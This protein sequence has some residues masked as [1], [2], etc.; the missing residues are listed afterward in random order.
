MRQKLWKLSECPIG[1]FQFKDTLCV[2]NEYGEYF[3]VW[4]GE[5]FWGGAKTKQER[6]NLLVL[7]LSRKLCETLEDHYALLYKA[8]EKDGVKDK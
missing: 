5:V 6:D 7:P 4:S 2:K 3:I 8:L 1:L